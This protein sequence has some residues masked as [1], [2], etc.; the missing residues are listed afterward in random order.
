M[1]AAR[2]T[3]SAS[4]TAPTSTASAPRAAR[5]ANAGQNPVTYPFKSFDGKQTIEQQQSGERVY[6]INKDGV[7]HYGLYPD[8]IE[9]LRKIAGDQI[10]KDMARGSEAYLQMW[11]RA[12][13]RARAAAA[14]RRA[15]E[16]HPP[17]PR[18]VAPRAEPEALLRRAGQ[19]QRGPA[20]SGAG[21][22]RASAT[23][24]KTLSAVFTP[25]WRVGLIATTGTGHRASR[26]G[27]A[28]AL[29]PPAR[30]A[31]VRRRRPGPR[32]GLGK[33]RLV[34]GVRA[35][36]CAVHRGRDP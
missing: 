22:W 9:D 23:R 17:R 27:P 7:A 26:V 13:R 18:H 19:P 16:L 32:S 35:R 33:A 20:G 2:G 28:R 30:H 11:E 14:A 24:A 31:R 3:T 36:P 21:A 8:W 15:R 4:A 34:Y 25:R 29:A 6:D 1:R 12:E 5:R 10:V